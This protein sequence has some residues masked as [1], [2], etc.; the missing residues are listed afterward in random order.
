MYN[1]VIDLRKKTN[2]VKKQMHMEVKE[3]VIRV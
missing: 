2:A 3:S 1:M